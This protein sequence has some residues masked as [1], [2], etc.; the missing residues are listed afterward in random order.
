[1]LFRTSNSIRNSVFIVKIKRCGE[2]ARKLRLFKEQMSK[3][4]LLSSSTSSTQVDLSFDDLEVCLIYLFIYKLLLFNE[5]NT[6]YLCT[7]SSL[8]NLKQS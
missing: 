8:E 6:A 3:A 1:M 2:M 4:G 5:V 7:R